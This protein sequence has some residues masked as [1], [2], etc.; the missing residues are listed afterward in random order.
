LS[1][2]LR[3]PIRGLHQ[4]PAHQLRGE[5]EEVGPVLPFDSLNLQD[6]QNNMRAQLDAGLRELRRRQGN[7]GLPAAPSSAIAPPPRPV[8]ADAPSAIDAN[9]AGLLEARQQ[10]AKQAE[11]EIVQTAFGSQPGAKQQKSV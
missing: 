1:G 8:M 7:G 3:S 4:Y 2:E 9:V 11:S 5:S 6:V 10:E